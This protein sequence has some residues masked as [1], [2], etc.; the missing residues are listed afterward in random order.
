MTSILSGTFIRLLMSLGDKPEVLEAIRVCSEQ[1]LS[2]SPNS[3]CLISRFSS[4]ASNTKS[5]FSSAVSRSVEALS[6]EST[7]FAS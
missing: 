4:T 6:R 1:N 7:S 3:R 2:I 5:A